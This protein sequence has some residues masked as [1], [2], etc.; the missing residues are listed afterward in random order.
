MREEGIKGTFE[1]DLGLVGSACDIANIFRKSVEQGFWQRI[2]L[3]DGEY[4]VPQCF[5]LFFMVLPRWKWI[6]DWVLIKLFL[7]DK[8][9]WCM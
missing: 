9:V 8:M 4:C 5:F 2:E 1:S 3:E 6:S 7:L